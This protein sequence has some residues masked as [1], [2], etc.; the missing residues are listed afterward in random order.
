MTPAAR[1]AAIGI[2]LAGATMLGLSMG[3]RQTLG[4]FLEPMTAAIGV[5]HSSFGLAIAIQN[6]LWGALTPAFGA[7]ADRWGTGRVLVLGALLYVGGL[8]IYFLFKTNSL[9]AEDNVNQSICN[10]CTQQ[11]FPFRPKTTTHCLSNTSCEKNP[12]ECTSDRLQ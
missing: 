12:I 1:R 10:L 4:L 2:A 7:V 11:R 9:T 8:A 5:S 6:L 3:L